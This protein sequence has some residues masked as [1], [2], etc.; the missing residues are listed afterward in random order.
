MATVARD[1]NG[2]VQPVIIVKVQG[3]LD[4]GDVSEYFGRSRTNAAAN[5]KLLK[6]HA[7]FPTARKPWGATGQE[8]W[9]LAELEEWLLNACP[10][11]GPWSTTRK[12]SA[13]DP[14]RIRAQ[15]RAAARSSQ[16]APV[17]MESVQ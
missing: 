11:T 12:W 3:L 4:A 16:P 17:P 7:S 14:R 10:R 15:Q 2:R 13:T 6:R 5:I 1:R 8:G 9:V